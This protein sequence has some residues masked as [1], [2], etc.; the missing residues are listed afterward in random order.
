VLISI[1]QFFERKIQRKHANY[2]NKITEP[3]LRTSGRGAP[4]IW[5]NTNYRCYRGKEL[6]D[7]IS[8]PLAGAS[9][10]VRTEYIIALFTLNFW[11]S[12]LRYRALT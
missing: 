2:F 10:C 4:P 1:T 9:T 7:Q 3:N 6:L 11:K 8:G 12:D 5:K